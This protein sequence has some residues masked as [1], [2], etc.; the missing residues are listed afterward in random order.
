MALAVYT[1]QPKALV[2]SILKAIDNGAVTA[3]THLSAATLELHHTTEPL[4]GAA[5]FKVGINEDASGD[6]VVFFGMNHK[7]ADTDNRQAIYATLHGA[8]AQFLL[9]NFSA[10][11]DEITISPRLRNHH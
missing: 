9:A 8:L 7:T 6:P 4:A 10:Q 1:K 3:W 5:F 2:A 11:I